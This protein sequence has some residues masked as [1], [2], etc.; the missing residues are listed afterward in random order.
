MNSRISTEALFIAVDDKTSK[1][2]WYK[3]LTEAQGFKM[4]LNIV[5]QDNAITIKLVENGK[6]SSRK[7]TRHF[8][9][10]LFH[11]TDLI[12]RKEVVIKCCLPGKMLADYFSKPLVGK[13]FCMIRSDIVNVAFKE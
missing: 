9:I 11:I 12:K 7:R 5:F 6:L 13:L 10:R 3:S 8:E 4:N 1:V 2:K